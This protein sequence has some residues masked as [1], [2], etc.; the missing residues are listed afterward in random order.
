MEKLKIEYIDI[1]ELTPYENNA[2]IHTDEQIEHICN[3][4]KEFGFADP[5]GITGKDNIIVEGH[6]RLI[7]AKK[8]GMKTVPVIRLDHLTEE[9]RKM[10]TL[11][12][13]QTTMTTGWDDE[14]LDF[15]LLDLADDFNIRDFGFG[16]EDEDF[17]VELPS[18]DREPIRNMTFT[19]S[20]EQHELIE[21]AI[22]KA[23]EFNPEDPAGINENS[24]GNSLY[25]ICEV[26][27]NG[28]DS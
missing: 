13:N 27:K 28:L 10:Y 3:S 4:I 7:S 11:T 24:N 2:K 1:N 12:H 8:L 23:K 5:I 25:Y 26:F 19:V 15:E 22:K 21:E 17:E 6:G 18:G 9:Q 16:F 14:L 20:D